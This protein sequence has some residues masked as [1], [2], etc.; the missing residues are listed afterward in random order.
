MRVAIVGAAWL[1][2]FLFFTWLTRGSLL[3]S[4]YEGANRRSVLLTALAGNLLS[5]SRG[6]LVFCP[7]LPVVVAGAWRSSGYQ[8]ALARLASVILGLHMLAISTSPRWWA[9][10]CYGPRLVT[11]MVPWLALL[12]IIACRVWLEPGSNGRGRALSRTA[13]MGL[14]L[15]LA[16]S[17]FVHGVGAL[18]AKATPWNVWPQP[19][20]RAPQRLWDFAHPQFLAPFDP[21]I[22]AVASMPLL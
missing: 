21:G 2:A 6:V 19:V 7:W 9:G 4:Y 18:S 22:P 16:W 17:V 3:P 20:E 12:A 15:L 13:A 14:A 5:P 11:E 8:L 10:H 1:G